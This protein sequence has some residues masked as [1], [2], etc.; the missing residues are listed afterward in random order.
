MEERSFHATETKRVEHEPDDVDGDDR[1]Q[2]PGGVNLEFRDLDL[3]GEESGTMEEDD[4][5]HELVKQ[6]EEWKIGS[7][8]QYGFVAMK[9]IRSTFD[10]PMR[11]KK[12]DGTHTNTICTFRVEE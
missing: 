3:C 1:D 2:L 7:S 9:H 12:L 5:D 8:I 4:R 6:I 10:A 11:R